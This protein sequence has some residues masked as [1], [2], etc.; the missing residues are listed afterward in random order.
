MTEHRPDHNHRTHLSRRAFIQRLTAGA[1]GAAGA[2]FAYPVVLTFSREWAHAAAGH[3]ASYSAA[4]ANFA[5]LQ[6]TPTP[7]L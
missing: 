2:A 3:G 4:S 6:A 5:A 1:A 7:S